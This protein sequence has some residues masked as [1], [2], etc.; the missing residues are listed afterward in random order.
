EQAVQ[1]ARD[2][3]EARAAVELA[4]DVW[5]V[6]IEYRAAT[7]RQYGA[8]QLVLELREQPRIAVRGTPDHD[9][10]DR[11]EMCNH[12]HDIVQPTVQHDRDVGEIAFQPMYACMVERWNLSILRR[13][14][15]RQDCFARMDDERTAARL[16][17]SR[18]KPHEEC[19]VV[20]VVDAEATF[21]RDRNCHCA[22]HGANAIANAL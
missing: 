11:I 9:T 4:C 10:V 7:R 21:H 16:D 12:V 15:A 5:Q 19:V 3:V 20:L 17:D 8:I 22:S 6:T 13:S 1:M 2:V 18:R 14:Q